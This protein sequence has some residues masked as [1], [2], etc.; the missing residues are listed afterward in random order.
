ML[1]IKFAPGDT[2]LFDQLYQITDRYTIH[3][4]SL[5]YGLNT[6]DTTS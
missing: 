5:G 4:N 2:L 1:T 6:F 3:S